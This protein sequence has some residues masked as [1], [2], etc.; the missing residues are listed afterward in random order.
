MELE[1][2]VRQ[3]DQCKELLHLLNKWKVERREYLIK[4]LCSGPATE[5]LNVRGELIGLDNFFTS[6]ASKVDNGKVAKSLLREL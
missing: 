1:Q 3:A 2:E 5:V 4:L 6:L